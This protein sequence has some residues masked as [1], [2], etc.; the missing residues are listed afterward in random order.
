MCRYLT[1]EKQGLLCLIAAVEL[2]DAG[3]GTPNHRAL[4]LGP[5]AFS[6]SVVDSLGGNF[7]WARHLYSRTNFKLTRAA[8]LA[9]WRQLLSA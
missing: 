4:R 6:G 5:R 7:V 2:Q 9:E 3:H 8:A 1:V